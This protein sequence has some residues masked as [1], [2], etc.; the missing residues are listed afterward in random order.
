MDSGFLRIV[1]GVMGPICILAI[2]FAILASR[3][4]K[5]GQ[6]HTA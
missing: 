6:V 3:P 5:K 2:I 4:D 1:L